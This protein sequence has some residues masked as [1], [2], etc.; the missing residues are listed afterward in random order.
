[1][2]THGMGST[3]PPPSDLVNCAQKIKGY[4]GKFIFMKKQLGNKKLTSILHLN[5]TV[6]TSECI[7]HLE[8][9]HEDF[10]IRYNDLIKMDYPLWCVDVENNEPGD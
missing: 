3:P 4:I 10:E 5:T 9:H 8:G 7:V 6:P 1:M 2:L